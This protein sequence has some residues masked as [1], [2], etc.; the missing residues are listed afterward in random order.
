MGGP[1]RG[2]VRIVAETGEPGAIAGLVRKLGVNR[3]TRLTSRATMPRKRGTTRLA[4]SSLVSSGACVTRTPQSSRDNERQRFSRSPV[5]NPWNQ[6][7]C[8]RFLNEEGSTRGW[9]A[10]AGLLA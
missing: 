6:S 8:R 7:P 9:S 3:K 4:L 5:A 2:T 1:E 10:I